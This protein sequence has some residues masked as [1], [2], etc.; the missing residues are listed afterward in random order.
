MNMKTI[1]ALACVL[2]MAGATAAQTISVSGGATRAASLDSTVMVDYALSTYDSTLEPGDTGTLNLVLRNNGLF[3]AE[4][5][6]VSIADTPNVKIAKRFFLGTIQ[7]GALSTV[8]FTYRITDS[9]PMGIQTLS[10]Q[11]RYD[12]YDSFGVRQE[13]LISTYDLPLKVYGSPRISVDQVRLEGLDIGSPFTLTLYLKNQNTEAYKTT[14]TLEGTSQLSSAASA[15]S[16]SPSAASLLQMVSANPSALS[17]LASAASS[18][19]SAGEKTI[20]ILDTNQKYLGTIAKGETVPVTFSAYVSEKAVSGA[21]TLPLTIQYENKGKVA[22]TEE[23]E[24][25]VFVTGKPQISFTNV[26]TDPEE[27]HQDEK[28]VEV[29]VTV[30]NIGTKEVENLK[31]TLMPGGPFKNAKSYVQTKDMGRLNPKDSSTVSFYIDVDERIQPGLYD[32]DYLIEYQSEAKNVNETKPVKVAVKDS[33]DFALSTGDVKVAPGETSKIPIKVVNNGKKCDSVT[34]WVMKKSD[35]PFD[36]QD[37]SQYIG[38]LDKGESGEASIQFT[39]D[40]TASERRYLVPV[41]VRCTLDNKVEVSSESASVTVVAAQKSLTGLPVQILLALGI[42][43][44]SI[45]AYAAYRLAGRPGGKPP[46]TQKEGKS[47]DK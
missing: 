12:G 3:K 27:I 13:D 32:L 33:P 1:C 28:D 37:K 10:I 45:A 40:A 5:L 17:S 14:V 21:Y 26:K 41:E 36:F 39:A 34:I 23:L 19:S 29:K 47:Q 4:K 11:L 15:A 38:D 25:G 30:E 42:V 35:Q 8:S 22:Q 20:T 44:L 46:K 2:F 24:I 6:E 43:V 9:A 31:M 18:L 7:P 16:Q